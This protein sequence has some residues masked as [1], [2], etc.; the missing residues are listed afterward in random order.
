MNAPVSEITRF[1]DQLHD[2]VA[3]FRVNGKIIYTNQAFRSLLNYTKKQFANLSYSKITPPHWHAQ[4]EKILH[5]QVNNKPYSESF[6]KE[7]ISQKGIK[8]PV[9]CRIESIDGCDDCFWLFAYDISEEKQYI[10]KLL[11]SQSKYRAIF[12]AAND[13]IFIH[14]VDTGKILDAN[15]KTCLM[16]GYTRDE[17][18]RITVE[19]LSSG[20][21]PYTNKD[22][23][24][25]IKKALQLGPQIFEWH[26]KD[27]KGNLFWV[28]V[29]LKR[30]SIGGNDLLLAV[31]RDITDRKL[32]E[33]YRDQLIAHLE[34]KNVEMERFTYTIS[35]DLKSPLFTIKGFIEMAQRN[36]SQQAF[37]LL[38]DNLHRIGRAAQ[39]IED[40]LNE[41]MNVSQMDYWKMKTEQVS[42][43]SV[44]AEAVELLAS[45]INE[46]NVVVTID[47]GLPVVEGDRLRLVSLLQNLLENAIKYM[48]DNPYPAIRVGSVLVDGQTTVFVK[49]NGSG[50]DIDNRKNIFELF[51]QIDG[52]KKGS[53]LGLALAKHIVELH[54][55]S[56]WV[57]SEGKGKGTTFYFTLNMKKQL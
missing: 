19:S 29:S 4:D 57:E 18:R 8:I 6:E 14:D 13:A 44:A 25:H 56:I 20:V 42:L 26:A 3:C 46:Q 1:L 32:T 48:E 27:K 16:Y 24:A 38:P 21:A 39:R 22:A 11:H 12:D 5:N 28:E 54:N 49:D 53:G 30:S 43:K 52:T 7:F 23:L 45:S 41:L 35:H 37:N 33:A 34:A 9:R 51:Y 10:D 17:L 31:V 55:G 50:I 36:I 2:P 40:M 47:E 15:L